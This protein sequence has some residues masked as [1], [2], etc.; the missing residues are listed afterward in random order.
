MA[1]IEGSDHEAA[2]K[3]VALAVRSPLGKP[4]ARSAAS[5]LAEPKE[6]SCRRLPAAMV[7]AARA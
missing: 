1:L 6:H 5:G 7:R 3:L 4:L 2:K